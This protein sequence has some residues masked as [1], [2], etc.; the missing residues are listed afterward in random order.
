MKQETVNL[1]KYAYSEI[2]NKIVNCVFP[3]GTLLNEKEL[4]GDLSISRTPIRE[5]LNHL[6]EEGLIR[7]MPKKGIL[8]SN[9]TIDDMSQIYQ[10]RLELEPF[11]VRIAGPHLNS[12][13]LLDFRERFVAEVDQSDTMQQLETDTSFHRYLANNCGN[14]YLLQLVNKV[15]DENKRVVITASNTV[16]IHHSH[17][18]H[19]EIIDSLLTGDYAASSMVMRNHIESC[20]DATFSYF[21]QRTQVKPVLNLP[22]QKIVQ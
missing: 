3:P 22:Q 18:E 13:V 9:I 12:E 8:V 10:V 19:I 7:I 1:K 15:L 14:K 20:R 21:L 16:R 11:V 6:N 5:A 4:A 2:K 17:D